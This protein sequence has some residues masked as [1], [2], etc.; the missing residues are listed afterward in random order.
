MTTIRP[1]GPPPAPQG[2]QGQDAT[3]L[4]AARAFFAAAMGQATVPATAAASGAATAPAS[5]PIAKTSAPEPASGGPARI[6]RPGSLI[7]IRV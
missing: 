7:D 6:P 3:K 5:A 1:S 2:V 4:A